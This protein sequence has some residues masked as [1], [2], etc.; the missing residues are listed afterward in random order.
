MAFEDNVFINCPLDADYYALLKSILFTVIYLGLVPRIAIGCADSGEPRINKIIE[1][2]D[3]SKY[4]I[5]DLSRITA[6]RVNEFF[7][8]NMPF[9][10]GLDIGCRQFGHRHHATKRCLILEAEQ[11]RYQVALSDIAG[12]DIAAHNNRPQRA[13]AIVRNWASPICRPDS[14]GAAQVW[15]SFINFNW[16]N[17]RQLKARGYSRKDIQE[18]SIPELIQCM[19]H[20][21]ANQS[22]TR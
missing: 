20:W 11:Y 21:V 10:L 8:L 18:L 13:S 6:K 3:Q 15:Q 4:A 7:R 16:E 17:E 22:V 2:I 1:L 19:T 14:A 9:E 12:S 5:H